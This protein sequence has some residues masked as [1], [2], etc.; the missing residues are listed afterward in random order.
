[1]MVEDVHIILEM[2]NNILSVRQ[3]MEKE[4]EI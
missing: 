3:L 1:M 2:K 4:F